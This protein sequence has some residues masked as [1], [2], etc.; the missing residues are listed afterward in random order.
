MNTKVNSHNLYFSITLYPFYFRF[1]LFLQLLFFFFLNLS[2]MSLKTKILIL[3]SYVFFSGKKKKEIIFKWAF[4]MRSFYSPAVASVSILSRIPTTLCPYN[5]SLMPR[6][7][8]HSMHSTVPVVSS[9]PCRSGQSNV[10]RWVV[11]LILESVHCIS[12][13]ELA[14]LEIWYFRIRFLFASLQ[15]LIF[16][17]WKNICCYRSNFIAI[18]DLLKY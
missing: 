13:M 16:V 14:A 12:L 7:R 17:Y 11:F 15:C 6:E 2:I 4:S 3:L 10:L 1:F 18:F 8:S 9:A 5:G